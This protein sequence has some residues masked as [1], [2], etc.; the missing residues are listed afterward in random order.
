MPTLTARG[1]D[2]EAPRVGGQSVNSG[3]DPVPSST[4]VDARR[5]LRPHFTIIDLPVGTSVN[6]R[7]GPSSVVHGCG[8]VG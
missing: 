7:C 2:E 5:Q 8:V 1:D 6:D 4:R 3:M